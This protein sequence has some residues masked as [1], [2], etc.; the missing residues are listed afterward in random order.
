MGL[1]LVPQRSRSFLYP[2]A[3]ELEYPDAQNNLGAMY[4][5]GGLGVPKDDQVAAE[6]FRKTAD[7]GFAMS[8]NTLGALYSE[9]RGLPR[10]R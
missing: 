10:G 8:Q 9:R 5:N 7:K 1:G 4:L 2:K 3:V 6:F